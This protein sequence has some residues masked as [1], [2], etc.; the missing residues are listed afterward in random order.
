M[1][2]PRTF[3]IFGVA[4]FVISVYYNY[5][6][7]DI[8][9]KFSFEK[10]NYLWTS[11]VAKTSS[12]DG[13][14][15][16]LA[17]QWPISACILEVHQ[18]SRGISRTTKDCRFP[19]SIQTWTIHGIWPGKK[20]GS[21]PSY[22]GGKQLDGSDI[23]NITEE[24]NTRWP[25]IKNFDP[26]IK[27]WQYQWHKHGTCF[28][29][30]PSLSTPYLYFSKALEL[31]RKYDLNAAFKHCKILPNDS[32]KYSSNDLIGCIKNYFN[33]NAQIYLA[34]SRDNSFR[35]GDR[36]L[37]EVRMC[38]DKNDTAADCYAGSPSEFYYPSSVENKYSSS[39]FTRFIGG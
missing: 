10:F 5:P 15:Y 16:M 32:V 18:K 34:Y 19:P 4:G 7:S 26:N 20:G 6:I 37:V 22:C 8:L 25:T 9:S 31:N 23:S 11:L 27:F 1:P 13:Y 17:Q 24:L 30:E 29:D 3:V 33:W 35:N 36:I 39:I 28:Q 14:S 2:M 21:F 12:Y 38:F